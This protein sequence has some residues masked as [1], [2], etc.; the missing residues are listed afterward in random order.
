ME[1][2]RNLGMILWFEVICYLTRARTMN[3]KGIVDEFRRPKRAF[4]AVRDLFR[5]WQ[6]QV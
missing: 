4:F 2:R 1:K 3:N 6:E 5:Q